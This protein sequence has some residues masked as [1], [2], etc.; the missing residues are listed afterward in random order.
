[1]VVTV[2]E[3]KKTV[4]KEVPVTAYVGGACVAVVNELDTAAVNT[5]LRSPAAKRILPNDLK[6][7]WSVKGVDKKGTYFQLVALKTVN[8][9]AALGDEDM[10]DDASAELQQFSG[11]YEVNMTMNSDAAAKWAKVTRENVGN[12]VA[13]V[14]DDKAS[15][16]GVNN[17]TLDD[18]AHNNTLLGIEVSRRLIN[19]VNKIGRASCRERV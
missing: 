17:E 19:K 8:G 10:I 5:I 16:L 18:L 1:M 14:L 11:S 2:T 6:C 3:N 13:I 15:L 9:E 7:A 4:E 12:Q